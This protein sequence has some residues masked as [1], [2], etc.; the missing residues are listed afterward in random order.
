MVTSTEI[1]FTLTCEMLK[2]E[3]LREIQK[4]TVLKVDKQKAH[5]R[6]VDKAIF[7]FIST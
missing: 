2:I 6:S 3:D 4:D 5:L 1:D 7:L